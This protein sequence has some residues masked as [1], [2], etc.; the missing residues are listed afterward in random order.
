MIS[1]FNNGKKIK[2][3]SECS[4]I[5]QQPTREEVPLPKPFN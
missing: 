2:E 5:M 3:Q 1:E 4:F